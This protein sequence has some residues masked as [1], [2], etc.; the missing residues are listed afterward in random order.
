MLKKIG[1]KDRYFVC[2]QYGEVEKE[3]TEAKRL[4]GVQVIN[5]EDIDQRKD[6]D[7]L[8]NLISACDHVVSVDNV[9]VHLAG[10]LGVSTTALIPSVP[11][12][13]WGIKDQETHWYS[14][15]RLHRQTSPSFWPSLTL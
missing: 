8:A 6:L 2:L 15:V 10:A 4:L 11:D 14:S 5:P 12:W 1:T 7:N 13:R 3:I 9:T